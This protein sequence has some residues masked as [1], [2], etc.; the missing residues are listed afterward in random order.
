ML[1]KLTI[2]IGHLVIVPPELKDATTPAERCEIM[3]AHHYRTHS[4]SRWGHWR[5]ETIAKACIEEGFVGEVEILHT[6]LDTTGK[7]RGSTIL[8]YT[9]QL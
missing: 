1:K 4:I 9:L 2:A 3:D 5:K 7:G 6:Y 8:V